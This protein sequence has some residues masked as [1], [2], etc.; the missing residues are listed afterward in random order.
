MGVEK[1]LYSRKTESEKFVLFFRKQFNEVK[2]F[3]SMYNARCKS[4]NAGETQFFWGP[5]RFRQI[6]EY[7]IIGS[8]RP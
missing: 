3:T 2:K 4:Q 5:K 8:P 1:P 7:F 6:A